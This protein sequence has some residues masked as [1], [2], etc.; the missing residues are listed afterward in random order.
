MGGDGGVVATNRR[1]MR[2]AG[3]ADHTGDSTAGT[4]ASAA[5]RKRNQQRQALETLTTCAITGQ[6]FQQDDVIVACRYGRLYLKEAAVQV[7]LKR[8]TADD[9]LTFPACAS[10]SS[11]SESALSHVHKL[12]E[13]YHVRGTL[14]LMTLTSTLIQWICPITGK[15]LNGTVPPALLLVPGNPENSNVVSEF[16][17][18]KLSPTDLETDYGPIHRK[19]RLAPTPEQLIEMQTELEQ[20]RWEK[21]KKKTKKRTNKS[22]HETKDAGTKRKRLLEG[23]EKKE[24]SSVNNKLPKA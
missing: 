15:P 11:S 6:K 12:C 2:G 4:A 13:L 5:D 3:T 8:K 19:I 14:N 1:Y 24:E 17:L 21:T 23:G 20:E 22:K 16:A 10:A 7:L 18:P 9:T